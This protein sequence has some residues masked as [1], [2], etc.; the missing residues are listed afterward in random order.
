MQLQQFVGEVVEELGGVVIPVE[1]ALCQVLIPER[2]APYFQNKTELMIAFD[3]EVAEE[4]PDAEFV[5]F[6]SY[7]LEQLLEIIQQN[8][9]STI[10][11]V[12][13]DRLELGKPLKKISEFLKEES[14]RITIIDEKPAM[15]AWAVF[16]YNVSYIADEKTEASEQVWVNLLTNQVSP[17]MKQEQNRIIYQQNP[18]Y[19]YPLP[20]TFD[21]NHAFTIAT[22]YVKEITERQKKD[23]SNSE[24]MAKDVDRIT[25]YYK[26]LVEENDKRANRKGLSE[27]KQKEYRSKSEAIKLERD[28]QL[29]EIRNKYNGQIEINID[30]GILYFIPLLE[31]HISLEFRA[32]I[33]ERILYFNPITKQFFE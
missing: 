15:G 14:G 25:N 11:F 16:Q 12:E 2:Y 26:E 23:G 5:T 19:T 24:L 21:V 20:A 7:I 33:S 32:T 1:Y 10:R 22:T 4:N 9:I 6:G 18:I 31:F 30:N 3:F 28:K 8:A 27:E 13:I 29:Q 17:T